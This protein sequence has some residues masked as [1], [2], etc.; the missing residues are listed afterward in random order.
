MKSKSVFTKHTVSMTEWVTHF[1]DDKNVE[2]FRLEDNTKDDRL[3]FLYKTIGLTYERP[4][5]FEATELKNNL[6]QCVKVLKPSDGDL[7]ALRLN[8]KSPDFPKIRCR[9][10]TFKEMYK[11]FLAQDVDYNNYIAS[12]RPHADTCL[13]ALIVVVN[14]DGI[15]GE[16]TEGSH[17][18]LTQGATEKTTTQFVFDYDKWTWKNKTD[19]A[20]KT[21]KN[22]INKLKVTNIEK[23]KLITNKLK[24]GFTNDIL[25][26]YYEIV[27]WNDGVIRFSDYNRILYK[28]IK[29]PVL[30]DVAT[31]EVSGSSV[32]K[33]KV[34]GRVV[35]VHDG[36]VGKVKFRSGAVLVTD[37]TDVRYISYMNKS[38]AI[39]TDRGGLLSHAAIVARELKKPCIIGTKIATKVLK[40]GDLVEVDAEKGTVTIIKKAK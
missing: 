18:E 12:F 38:A 25:H 11:W 37:N 26:G 22:I 27:L 39:V 17:S 28:K 1:L 10:L 7:F 14:K 24:M 2:R 36:N 31:E 9:G 6:D 34:R 16:M 3:E 33:G 30:T 13:L 5:N 19:L 15:F 20:Q 8:P 40:D 4:I 23:R 29:K 32:Y 21:I 35:I